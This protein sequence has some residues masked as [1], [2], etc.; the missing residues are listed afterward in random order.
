[1][2][3][4][5]KRI[6]MEKSAYE[7]KALDEELQKMHSK[8]LGLGM[9]KDYFSKSKSEILAKVDNE[10]KS[11]VFPLYKNKNFWAAAAVI[12]VLIVLTVFK[13]NTIPLINEI[14]AIVTDTIENLNK[15]LANE[16]YT[17]GEDDILITSLFIE[18]TEIDEFVNNYML[19][20][21]ISDE[22]NFK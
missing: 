22:F 19:E 18:E 11:K 14:P 9:P 15:G 20:E 13:T 16:D 10:H 2:E 21:A 4:L 17:L 7:Q 5:N 1:M 3:S 6:N 12:A 8:D